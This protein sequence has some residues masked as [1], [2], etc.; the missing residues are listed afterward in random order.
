MYRALNQWTS[1]PGFYRLSGRVL[2]WLWL[3]TVAVFAAG[4]AGGLIPAPPDHGQGM[5]YRI[6]YIHLPA[7]WMAVFAYMVMAGS[8]LIHL[9]RRVTLADIW[10]EASAPV[11]AS[12]AVLALA[13]GSLWGKPM[14]GAWWVWDAHLTSVLILFF[15]FLGYMALRSAM[16]ERRLAA[17]AS[18][19]LVLVGV[20]HVPLIHF[21]ATWWSTLHQGSTVSPLDAPTIH[22]GMLIPLL[23][24]AL[25]FLLYYLLFCLMRARC[26][27]LERECR[28]HWVM[29]LARRKTA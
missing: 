2:P 3:F 8:A 10:A 15:L 29:E 7:V 21:S 1:P 12:F 19:V 5:A 13:T 26:A 27:I 9:V 25:A 11:G 20:V 16:D 6:I 17:R 24:M 28:S 18:A 22:P 23:I 14:W 4:L